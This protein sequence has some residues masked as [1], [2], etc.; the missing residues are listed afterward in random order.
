MIHNAVDKFVYSEWCD[1]TVK[2]IEVLRISNAFLHKLKKTNQ[3]INIKHYIITLSERSKHS[4]YFS[5][6]FL[7]INI[8][9]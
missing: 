4:G 6:I 1:D 3:Y 5:I 9:D 2:L 8:R 7:K